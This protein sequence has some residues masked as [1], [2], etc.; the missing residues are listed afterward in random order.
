M[1]AQQILKGMAGMFESKD[2]KARALVKEIVVS[3]AQ[4]QGHSWRQAAAVAIAG[5][6]AHRAQQQACAGPG[7]GRTKH[8]QVLEANV[9]HS[10]CYLSNACGLLASWLRGK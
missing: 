6:A 1:P 4:K 5:N 10:S 3:A 8:V 7:T 9:A 2:A